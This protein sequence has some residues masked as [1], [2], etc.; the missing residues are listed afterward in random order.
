MPKTVTVVRRTLPGNRRVYD[1]VDEQARM[2][3]QMLTGKKTVSS[4]DRARYEKMGVKFD[5]LDDTPENREKIP[6]KDWLARFDN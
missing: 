3:H 6:D 5:V 4:T 1:V 2:A